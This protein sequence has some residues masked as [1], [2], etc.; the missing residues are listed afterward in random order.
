MKTKK[1]IYGITFI[2]FLALIAGP[3]F[4]VGV[5]TAF[6]AE[7]AAKPAMQAPSEPAAKPATAAPSEPAAEPAMQAPAQPAAAPAK[8][9]HKKMAKKAMPSEKIKAVQKALNT[10]GFTLQEDG[11][12]GKKTKE[13]LKKFQA[14]N[15]LKVTGKADKETL[16]KLEIQ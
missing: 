11:F 16:A 1:L 8:A 9:A 5:K 15:G 12:M 4:F 7:E 2:C 6:S 3:M 13:A 14:D 10:A